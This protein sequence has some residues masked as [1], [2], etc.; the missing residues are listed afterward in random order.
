MDKRRNTTP[1][2]WAGLLA[3]LLVPAICGLFPP[4]RGKA[5]FGV[6][7]IKFELKL[8]SLNNLR[9][10]Q[11]QN[12]FESLTKQNIGFC[13]HAVRLYNEFNYRVFHY[14]SAPKL[15]L[16]KQDCFYENI[17]IDEYTGKDFIGNDSIEQKVIRFK[18]LQDNL[19]KKEGKHLVLVLEPGKVRYEPEFLPH[20]YVKGKQT[21]YD[22]F[23]YFLQKHNVHYLDLNR[24]FRE[25]K[26]STP[27]PLYSKHGIHWSTYGMWKATDTLSRFIIQQCRYELPCIRNVEDI[28]STKKKDLDFDLEPPMNLLFELPTESLCFPQMAFDDTTGLKRPNALIIAD[29]YVWSLWNNGIIQHWFSNPEF[30]YYNQC[31][32]PHIWAFDYL[33]IEKQRRATQFHDSDLILIMMTDANLKDFGWGA[34]EEIQNAIK[35]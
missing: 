1:I 14:S 35:P 32:Y 27:Y 6:Q 3:I 4:S 2:I 17:Y 8:F 13:N 31:V 29:S 30:W 5:L 15:I 10:H 20:G 23:V 34:I 24:Y 21:N 9:T 22:R 12:E 16:G 7:P 33:A 28:I 18:R 19:L 11:T 26:A 25:Q